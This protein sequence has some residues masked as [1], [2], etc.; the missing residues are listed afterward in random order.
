MLTV[1]RIAELQALCEAATPG[2]LEHIEKGRVFFP[3]G[4]LG[5]SLALEVHPVF[6]ADFGEDNPDHWNTG[7]QCVEQAARDGEFHAAA[8]TALPALLSDHRE[9]VRQCDA[10]REESAEL[11]RR[12]AEER[13]QRDQER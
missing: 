11:R 4:V 6:P 8:R 13:R 2:P 7:D 3:A 12:L 5:G 10:A 1:E 9:L